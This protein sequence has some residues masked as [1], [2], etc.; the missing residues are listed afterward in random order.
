LELAEESF[1]ARQH[2][3]DDGGDDGEKFNPVLP[4]ER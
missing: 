3:D 1:R 4:N 2:H